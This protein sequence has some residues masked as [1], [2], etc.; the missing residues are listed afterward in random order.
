MAT[1][2]VR[3][4]RTTGVAAFLVV[5]AGCMSFT[6]VTKVAGLYGSDTDSVLILSPDGCYAAVKFR[7]SEDRGW[8]P[9]IPQ[10]AGT[11]R[12]HQGKVIFASEAG[13]VMETRIPTEQAPGEIVWHE[14]RYRA[15]SLSANSL[16]SP[17]KNPSPDEAMLMHWREKRMTLAQIEAQQSFDWKVGSHD[18]MW[19]LFKVNIRHGDEL[20]RY[21]SPPETWIN[22]IGRQGYALFRNGRLVA[23]FD[24]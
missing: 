11:W 19:M 4:V 18:F 6:P 16:A 12:L 13:P 7:D 21:R 1:G 5:V 24:L 8:P 2:V 23:N 20:W 10:E 17:Q 15:T 14:V 9:Y 22:K 3:F